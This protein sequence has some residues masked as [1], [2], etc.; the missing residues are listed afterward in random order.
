MTSPI[1]IADT[2][3]LR[4]ITFNRPDRLNAFTADM[5]DLFN[6]ILADSASNNANIDIIVSAI[7]HNE[8]ATAYIKFHRHVSYSFLYVFLCC[9]DVGDFG[10]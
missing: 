9:L 8:F 3:G 1:L 7:Q 5:G 6:E 2:Y 4:S 10:E